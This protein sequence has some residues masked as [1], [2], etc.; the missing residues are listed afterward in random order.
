VSVPV[1]VDSWHPSVAGGLLVN[2]IAPDSWQASI[3]SRRHVR[4]ALRIPSKF[5]N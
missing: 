4:I 3:S 2:T 5:G 1:T